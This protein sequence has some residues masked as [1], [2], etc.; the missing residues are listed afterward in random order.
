MNKPVLIKNSQ[1]RKMNVLG[2]NQTI[3]M[4]SVDTNGQFTLIEQFDE[5]G[6]GIPKHIHFNEDE[7]FRVLEG[8]LKVTI[9]DETKFVTAGDTIYCPR[10]IPH[11]WEV[12][13]TEKAKTIL[14]IFPAGL[15][16][17]FEELSRLSKGMSEIEK[18]IEITSK[19]N[20]HFV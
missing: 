3:K 6:V 11:A 7:L 16:V 1:G 15:E 10:G 5:P 12:V 17:M 9:G 18:V 8:K 20:I 4:T 13:G 2:D 19:Y 14:M